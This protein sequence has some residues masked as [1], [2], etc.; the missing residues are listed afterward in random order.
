MIITDWNLFW[1]ALGAIGG[2]IGAFATLLAVI[3]ALWQTKYE[4]RK[5]LKLSKL[6]NIKLADTSIGHIEKEFVVVEVSNIGNIPPISVFSFS[7]FNNH[8]C[9]IK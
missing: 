7:L 8:L 3:V 1:T 6:G 2:T 5:K 9:L 4:T